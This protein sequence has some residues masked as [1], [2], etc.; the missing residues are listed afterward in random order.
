MTQGKPF[1]IDLVKK[2]N[3]YTRKKFDAYPFDKDVLK[4]LKHYS[5]SFNDASFIA[6]IDIK[7]LSN[8]IV[9]AQIMENQ[10]EN[11]DESTYAFFKIQVGKLLNMAQSALKEYNKTLNSETEKKETWEIMSQRLFNTVAKRAERFKLMNLALIPKIE[12]YY[13]LGITRLRQL[14]PLVSGLTSPDPIGDLLSAAKYTFSI[15]EDLGSEKFKQIAEIAANSL[16]LKKHNIPFTDHEVENLSKKCGIIPQSQAKKIKAS[17]SRGNSIAETIE[18]VKQ[19]APTVAAP[20]VDMSPS[21]NEFEETCLKMTK[22][23]EDI[24]DDQYV[25]SYSPELTAKWLSV[26]SKL[27]SDLSDFWSVKWADFERNIQ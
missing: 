23:M 20:S 12:D 17:V 10:I 15:D 18:K 26:M 9:K 1:P 21:Y 25:P 13:F 4:R 14:E 16:T 3:R 24:L 8:V 7:D 19:P 5:S 22:M 11:L 2:M 6:N 27:N